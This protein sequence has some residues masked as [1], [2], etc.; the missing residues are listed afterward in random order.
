[1]LM[2]TGIRSN[3]RERYLTRA[4]TMHVELKRR[5]LK[6]YT[7]LTDIGKHVSLCWI[8]SH[9]GIKGNEMA[10]KAAKD[11]ICSVITQGKIP[12]ESFFPHISKL[13]M[14]EWQ[15]SWDSILT[16][17]L[18]SIKPVLGKNKPRTSLC[19]RDET[20]LTRLRIGHS[21]VTHSYLL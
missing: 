6:L 3:R 18:F 5:S 21:R 13:C 20:V 12:P 19:R 10:N 9:V 2:N 14:K 11:G 4:S 17:K 7:Q 8:P 1:M 15:D 16:N